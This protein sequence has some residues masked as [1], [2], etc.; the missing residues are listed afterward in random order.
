MFKTLQWEDWMGVALGAWMLVS[1]WVIG[2]SAI[3][4]ATMNALVMGTILVLEEMLEL[5]IHESFEE[6]IDIVAGAW[7]VAAPFALGFSSSM[8]ATLN[9]ILVGTCTILLAVTALFDDRTAQLGPESA[10]G[11]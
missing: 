3:E 9:A 2:Y 1:P 6:W 7:L 10:A 11:H 4:A 5:G 8:G